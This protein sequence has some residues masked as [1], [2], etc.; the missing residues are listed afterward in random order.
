[1]ALNIKNPDVERLLDE[2]VQL[3][4][5][6]K[7][8]VVRKALEE[9]RQRIALRMPIQQ[10][11]TERILAFLQEE[12]WPQIPDSVLGTRLRK[13]EEEAILGYGEHGV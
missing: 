2:L 3:T 13:E 8:E 5:E 9:R 10:D 6:S 11:E 7:T 1:M 4:G 12:I